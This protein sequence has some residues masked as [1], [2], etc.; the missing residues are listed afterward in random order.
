ML[1][2]IVCGARHVNIPRN[3]SS[4]TT[5]NMGKAPMPMPSYT[6]P[7]GS[8]GQSNHGNHKSFGGNGSKCAFGSKLTWGHLKDTKQTL[9]VLWSRTILIKKHEKATSGSK[10]YH[11]WNKAKAKLT[12]DEFNKRRRTN[13]CI[14]CGEV[15]HKYSNCLKPKPWLLESV[16]DSTI[17]I[18]R[19]LIPKLSSI[20]NK[21]LVIKSNYDYRIDPIEH[22]LKDAINLNLENELSLIRCGRNIDT[23]PII[24]DIALSPNL[25]A[26][27]N[28]C[29]H[30]LKE[31]DAW[32]K[33]KRTITR[34]LLNRRKRLTTD[35][36]RLSDT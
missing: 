25:G 3:N 6:R 11:S 18:I 8:I 16:L 30:P 10:S 28:E 33:L 34:K 35:G 17:P 26:V 14:N 13:A 31:R 9:K 19:T 36:W 2:K 15:G 4:T 7:H 23:S 27:S 21:S 12:K 5:H 1:L 24:I 29:P 22:H 32:H 20:I